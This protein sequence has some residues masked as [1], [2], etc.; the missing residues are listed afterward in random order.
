MTLP[1]HGLDVAVVQTNIAQIQFYIYTEKWLKTTQCA[2]AIATSSVLS[3]SA[4]PKTQLDIWK[5]S[6]DTFFSLFMTFFPQLH[7]CSPVSCNYLLNDKL[8][9]FHQI[10]LSVTYWHC[11]LNTARHFLDD[12]QKYFFIIFILSKC[13]LILY[14]A[15]KDTNFN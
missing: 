10:C 9:C 15:D 5:S 11:Y 2:W 12:V 14:T 3:F 6:W 1:S 4:N 8:H 7:L 13:S